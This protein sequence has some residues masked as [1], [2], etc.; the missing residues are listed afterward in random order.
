MSEEKYIYR[1]TVGGGKIRQYNLNEH[2]W[3]GK[4]P[5]SPKDIYEI[6]QGIWYN[7]HLNGNP[8]KKYDK[9][10]PHQVS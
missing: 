1:E 8:E 10:K 6:N 7:P 3:H 2:P 4:K 5:L 9:V